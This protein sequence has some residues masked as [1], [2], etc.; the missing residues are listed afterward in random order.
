MTDT[1]K[2]PFHHLHNEGYLSAYNE[3]R[4]EASTLVVMGDRPRTSLAG[5]WHFTL[6]LFDEG[7]RQK[8]FML[9][10]AHPGEWTHP[11]DYD[12]YAGPTLNVPSNWSMQK[13]EWL[14]F[15]GAGWYTRIIDHVHDPLQPVTLLRIGAANYQSRIFLNGHFLGTHLGGSTPFCVD[16]SPRLQPGPNRLQIQVDNRRELERVP[17]RHFDWFNHGG[18][19]REVDLLRLPAVHIRHTQV[20]WTPA[21]GLRVRIHLNEPVD[22][23]AHC[24]IDALGIHLVIA[25]HAG[26]GEA[27]VACRPRLTP[28]MRLRNRAAH[29]GAPGSSPSPVASRARRRRRRCAR[30]SPRSRTSSS[31]VQPRPSRRLRLRLRLPPVRSG[32]RRRPVPP[33]QAC[34]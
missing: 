8:W 17:M 19:Y 29:A 27:S 15:E 23:Q 28:A 32:R 14:H 24:H 20:D 34:H 18:I 1:H 9:E 3:P 33:L 26:E 4:F 5:E 10:Q 16:L 31:A 21:Q 11:R 22:T 25:V 12:P 7:L 6:D 2:D 30:R 13:P